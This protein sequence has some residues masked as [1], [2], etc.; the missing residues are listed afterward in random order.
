[1]K[2]FK[3]VLAVLLT[4]VIL[5][6]S[7]MCLAVD[8]EKQYYDYDKVLLLGDSQASGHTD[9]DYKNTEFTRIDDSFAAYVADDLGAELLPFACPG[10]RTI[11]LRYMLDDNYRP[12]D[13]YLFSANLEDSPEKIIERI[14][15]IQKAVKEADLITICIGGND[16]GGYLGWVFEDVQLE[17]PLPEDVKNAIVEYLQ[18]VQVGDDIIEKIIS[19][20]N[21][22]NAADE[23]IMAIP[24]AINYCFEAM[25]ENWKAIVEIIYENNPDVTLVAVGL[26]GGYLKTEEGAP[27]VVAQPNELAMLVEDGIIANGNKFMVKYQPEYGYIYVAPRNVIVETSHPTPA[28]HRTIADAIL[29]A[30]P[31][32]RFQFN[33]D[34]ALRNPNYTAIEHMTIYGYMDGTSATTFSPDAPLTEADLSK[35]LNKID[36]SYKV[37]DSDKEVSSFKMAYKLYRLTDKKQFFRFVDIIN[38]SIRV[39]VKNDFKLTR[40]E[41][42]GILYS[43]LNNIAE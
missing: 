2:N 7:F 43:Y 30:L 39:I 36:E 28:G 41:G 5:S 20:G 11:E 35:A 6:G 27:D 38:F 42:A 13:K 23:L 15:A 8:S 9:Y 10:F 17:N 22:F 26:F 21:T 32:K 24:E 29:E 4:L 33:E 37:T 14:P 34:V 31:D 40:G 1:M 25:E 12:D 16:W 3:R 18:N 19:I